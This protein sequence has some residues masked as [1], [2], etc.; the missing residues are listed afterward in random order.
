MFNGP[1]PFPSNL[2][3]LVNMI[4]YKSEIVNDLTI[5]L[6]TL[7]FVQKEYGGDISTLYNKSQ[8]KGKALAK[9]VEF[10]NK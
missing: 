1:F 4:G 6:A 9:F 2:E 3:I 5:M 7:D 8:I 10:I